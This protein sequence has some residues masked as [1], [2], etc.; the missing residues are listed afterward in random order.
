MP[1]CD[2][3]PD[4]GP[5]LGRKE[6]PGQVHRSARS[7]PVRLPSLRRGFWTHGSVTQAWRG[8][9]SHGIFLQ[10]YSLFDE[11]DFQHRFSLY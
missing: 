8:Q 2:D 7:G 9:C 10:H 1:A 3:T 11:E 4:S 6:L 5:G